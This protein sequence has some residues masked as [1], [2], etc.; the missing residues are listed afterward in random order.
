MPY[1]DQSLDKKQMFGTC[2]L[3]NTNLSSH[4]KFETLLTQFRYR[5]TTAGNIAN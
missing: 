3:Y 2:I 1:Y 4:L 5:V